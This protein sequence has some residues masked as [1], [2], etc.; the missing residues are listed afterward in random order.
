MFNGQFPYRYYRSWFSIAMFIYWRVVCLSIRCT[1]C[2]PCQ[3]WCGPAQNRFGY[4]YV[5]STVLEPLGIVEKRKGRSSIAVASSINFPWFLG[6]SSINMMFPCFPW[7][8]SHCRKHRKIM[9]PRIFHHIHTSKKRLLNKPESRHCSSRA[10]DTA[11]WLRHISRFPGQLPIPHSQSRSW[12]HGT[13]GCDLWILLDI[14]TILGFDPSPHARLYI[15]S[16]YWR[17]SFE[18]CE[19]GRRHMAVS[20]SQSNTCSL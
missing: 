3:S 7:L 16:P 8:C 13:F 12:E 10:W 15:T 1:L 20:R 18:I 9:I 6:R 17:R 14:H 19:E 4:L 11:T 5:P 2:T